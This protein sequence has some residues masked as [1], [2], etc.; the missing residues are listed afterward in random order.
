[1]IH[2]SRSREDSRVG[3]GQP[4]IFYLSISLSLLH[5]HTRTHTNTHTHTRSESL[6]FHKGEPQSAM[7]RIWIRNLGRAGDSTACGCPDLSEHSVVV[8]SI[9]GSYLE[10]RALL[11][12]WLQSVWKAPS[13]TAEG[14]GLGIPGCGPKCQGR[15]AQHQL[16]QRSRS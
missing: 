16:S 14:A 10:R 2:C 8:S 11:G 6:S 5:T 15:A 13:I 1:M 7:T 9:L 12:T 4:S 3:V